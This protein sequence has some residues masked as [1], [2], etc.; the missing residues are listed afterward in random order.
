M[1]T[2]I[3]KTNGDILTTIN[4]YDIDKNSSPLVLLGRGVMNNGSADQTNM[5]KSLENF[6]NPTSPKNA[7]EGQLW[8]NNFTVDDSGNNTDTNK[9]YFYTNNSSLGISGWIGIADSR[10]I[11]KLQEELN[12]NADELANIEKH[13]TLLD[14]EIVTINGQISTINTDLSGIQKEIDQINSQLTVI[15]GDIVT[16]NSDISN[17]QKEIDKINADSVKYVYKNN[18]IPD[19]NVYSGDLGSATS[20]YSTIYA[21]MFNGTALRANWADL[22]EIY[23]TDY[24]Y[25]IGTVVR[26]GGNKEVTQ[27]TSFKDNK[28]LGV[29]SD[30]PAYLMN[31]SKIDDTHQPI[32]LVGR[33]FVRIIG[34]VKKGDFIVSSH[35]QGVGVSYDYKVSSLEV[36][37]ISLE[38]S[39]IE[40]E[41]LI[42]CYVGK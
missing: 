31:S 33:V 18:S 32:A 34:T 16:I 25:S 9:M 3:Y 13:L 26:I 14:G 20:A 27:T 29:I 6:C 21:T 12:S 24:N 5:V 8:Y 28:I 17:I 1:S 38:D 10:D 36:I 19:N 23:E 22:A 41:K 7:I 35:I 42:M 11:E 37:G 40:N 4:D 30:K 39:E 2:I 15:N